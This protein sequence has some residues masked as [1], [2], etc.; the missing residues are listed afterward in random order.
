MK[1]ALVHEWLTTYAGSDKVLAEIISLFPD[2]D[3]FCLIDYLPENERAAFAKTKI[4]TSFLQ[5]IPFSKHLYRH[6]FPLM[7]LA[8]EQH[9]LSDYDLVISNSHAVAK[10]VLTGADQLHICYCYTPIRYA[11]DFQHQYLAESKLTK[12]FRSALVRYLLH[13][14]RIWDSRTSNGVDHFIACSGYIARRI[15]KVY[16]RP[17]TVIYPNVEVDDFVI[18]PGPREDFYFTSSRM[19]PYKQIQLIVEAF[20]RMKDRKLVVIG[21]GPLFK[22]IQAEA[23]SNV[24]VLGFQPFPVLLKYMQK[25]RCFIFASE[26]DF[27]IAPLEAQACGTPVLAFGK[28]GARETVVDGVTG[29]FFSEQTPQ[30]ICEAVERFESIEHKFDPERIREHARGFSTE[31]FKAKFRSYVDAKWAEHQQKVTSYPHE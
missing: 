14:M 8:I 5:R 9:D 6:L 2:A 7:P 1:V 12:G 18:G 24:S 26:E 25:A 31:I 17:S 28:G 10:G 16:R 23:T 19:V 13:R 11:W 15:W 20:G 29:L 22:Q 27:G 30:A 21:T 3:L 4:R